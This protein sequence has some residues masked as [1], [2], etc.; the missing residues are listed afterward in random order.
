MIGGHNNQQKG[1]GMSLEILALLKPEP[2]T[3]RLL[4]AVAAQIGQSIVKLHPEQADCPAVLQVRCS[5]IE[6]ASYGLVRLSFGEDG[7]APA[8]SIRPEL[9]IATFDSS[10][11]E[12]TIG[13]LPE[14]D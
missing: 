10:D 12:P 5:G 9:L 4:A 2:I 1:N 7:D 13:F 11:D 8:V 3:Y 6:A 14:S